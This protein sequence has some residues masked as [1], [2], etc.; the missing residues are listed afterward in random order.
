[1]QCFR[2]IGRADAGSS[3]RHLGKRDHL[4]YRLA[5]RNAHNADAALSNSYSAMLKEPR[6]VRGNVEVVAN[7][8]NL[9]NVHQAM[10]F[11]V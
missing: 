7:F 9:L 8:E 10:E 2:H 4:E 5:R 3:P 6:S 11:Q 1:M